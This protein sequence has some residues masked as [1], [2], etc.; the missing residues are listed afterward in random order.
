[1]RI[2]ISCCIDSIHLPAEILS[3]TSQANIPDLSNLWMPFT[4]NR[5]F[6]EQPRLLAKAKGMYY[7]STAGHQ[8]MDATAG[9]WCVNAGHGRQEITNAIAQQTAELDYAPSFQLGHLD[10]F[11]AASAIAKLMPEGMD[12]IFFTN[13]GSES[14]DTSLKIALA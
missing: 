10:S 8:V 7:T 5:Q 3:M 14:V 6:K 12:R 1:M 11:R 2:A 13:S 9:L 4:A